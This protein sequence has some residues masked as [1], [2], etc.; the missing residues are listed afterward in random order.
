MTSVSSITHEKLDLYI[1]Q[2]H[3]EYLTCQGKA[4]LSMNGLDL[5]LGTC[6]EKPSPHN[7]SCANHANFVKFTQNINPGVRNDPIQYE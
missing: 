7:N 4:L 6:T 1:H 2:I 5:D 3:I